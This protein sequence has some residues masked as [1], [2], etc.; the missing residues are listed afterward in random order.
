MVAAVWGVWGGG[1]VVEEMVVE[2]G[3]AE[4]AGGA[5]AV[6]GRWCFR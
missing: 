4:V 2:A 5:T 6:L 3:G 1:T